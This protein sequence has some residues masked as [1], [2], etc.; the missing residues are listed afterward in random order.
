MK[1]LKIVGYAVGIG[2]AL[3]AVFGL[4]AYF[5]SNARLN[6]TFVVNP[7]QIAIAS[8]AATVARGKHIAETRGCSACHG[9][10]YGGGKVIEDPAMGRLYGPNLTR[11]RGGLPSG[12]SD[13]DWVRAIRH[14]VGPDQRGLFIMPSGE[15]SHLSD[16]DLGAV[17]AY[18][19]SVPPVDR[20]RVPTSY[21]PVSR[22]LLTL[23]K[24]KLAA[25]T[26]D[27][28]NINP[29][30]VTKAV[31]VEYGHY[32]AAGCVGCHGP[33]FSGGKIDIGPPSWPPARNLTPHPSGN[34]AKWTEADFMRALREG[35]RPDGSQLNEVMPRTFGGM[36]DTE[37]KALYVFF[38]S[39]PPVATGVR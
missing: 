29:P 13:T 20:E 36:D 2:V 11:G 7:R 33:N 15:Y 9:E 19:K 25:A 1:V 16:E 17:I 32:L 34:L 14:G 28:A 30:T 18:L 3:I 4:T 8:D 38:K 23:G 37:L 24:M 21:G 22:V 26:L 35:K 39:L 10:D 27:H 12:F 6:Q 5:V 31:S